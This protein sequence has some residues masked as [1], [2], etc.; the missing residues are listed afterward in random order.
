MPKG[1]WTDVAFSWTD[2][3]LL[4]H[5]V[6]LLG[7]QELFPNDLIARAQEE[8]QRT[9]EGALGP[10]ASGSLKRS[11]ALNDGPG[12]AKGGM[13]ADVGAE[14]L[15]PFCLLSYPRLCPHL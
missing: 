15:F 3:T 12:E 9:K 1:Q 7:V 6:R 10:F 4:A 5:R 13:A 11:Q 14:L 8:N 2:W